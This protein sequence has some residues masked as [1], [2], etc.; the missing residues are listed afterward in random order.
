MIF[1]FITNTDN[2][3]NQLNDECVRTPKMNYGYGLHNIYL[4]YL[5]L[6]S[7]DVLRGCF[8]KGRLSIYKKN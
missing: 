6:L 2:D 8:R 5:L 4:E 3:L 1:F 7:S